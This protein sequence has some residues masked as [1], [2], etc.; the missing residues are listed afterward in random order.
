M[1]KLLTET[2]TSDLTGL[3]PSTLR[4]GRMNPQFGLPFVR[5][6]RKIMYQPE[7]VRAFVEAHVSTSTAKAA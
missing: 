1:E 5:I 2:E 7:K 3:A 4:K 6:G